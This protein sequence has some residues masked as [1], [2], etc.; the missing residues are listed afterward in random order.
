[1]ILVMIQ[2]NRFVIVTILLSMELCHFELEPNAEHGPT[3]TQLIPSPHK[4]G[5]QSILSSSIFFRYF[6]PSSGT[7]EPMDETTLASLLPYLSFSFIHP[8]TVITQPTNSHEVSLL[9]LIRGEVQLLTEKYELKTV[10]EGEWFGGEGLLDCECGYTSVST[11][12]CV[13]ACVSEN[14]R[15]GEDC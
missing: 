14:S 6:I 10:H 7:L 3:K 1:M 9:I 2:S 12:E 4:E 13:C 5:I 11:K 15:I 8:N